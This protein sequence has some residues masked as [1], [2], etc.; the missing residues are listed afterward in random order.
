MASDADIDPINH[1]DGTQQS[2]REVHDWDLD[3]TGDELP[4]MSQ[5]S[6]YL[7]LFHFAKGICG[8]AAREHG[9]SCHFLTVLQKLCIEMMVSSAEPQQADGEVQDIRHALPRPS[10]RPKTREIP[11]TTVHAAKANK[12]V[13]MIISCELYDGSHDLLHLRIRISCC[14][15]ASRTQ[16][17]ST[18]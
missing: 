6:V 10:G 1:E 11:N 13:A 5:R 16:T 18:G 17:S 8:L 15:R 2:R 12:A 7:M 9:R 3:R 4:G 14:V